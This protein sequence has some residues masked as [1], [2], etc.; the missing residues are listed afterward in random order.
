MN[1]PPVL[2]DNP[3][4][5]CNSS[6]L[7]PYQTLCKKLLKF[8]NKDPEFQ[9]NAINWIKSLKIQQ[10]IKYFSF[11]NQWFVDILHEMLLISD[12]RKDKDIKYSFIPALNYEN[13]QKQLKEIKFV[14]YFI[15]CKDDGKI[16]LSKNRTPEDKLKKK[17]VENLRYVTLSSNLL[18]NININTN[19]HILNNYYNDEN[20]E[21]INNEYN[22][23]VTLSY[24]YLSDIDNL[25][26]TFLEISRN[27]CFQCPIEV[28]SKI[29]KSGKKN[30]YNFKMPKWLEEQFT[31]QELLCAYFEQSILI[32]YQYYLLYQQEIP[33][34]YYDKFDEFL[35]NIYKLQEFIFNCKESVSILQSIKPEEIKKIYNEDKNIKKIIEYKKSIDDEIKNNY[36]GKY[37]YS[38]KHTIKTIITTNLTTLGHVFLKDKLN[39]ILNMTFIKDSILFTTDDFVLKIIYDLI[40]NNWQSKVAE[41]LLNNY[42]MNNDNNKKRKKKKKNKKEGKNDEKNNELE[43]NKDHNINKDFEKENAISN[44]INNHIQENEDYIRKDIDNVDNNNSKKIIGEEQIEE[45]EKDNIKINLIEGK[46]EFIFGDINNEQDGNIY[47]NEALIIDNKTIE[48]EIKNG[49]NNYKEKEEKSKEK[50]GDNKN[51]K[52]EENNSNDNNHKKKKDKNFFLYPTLKNKKKKNKQKKKEKIANN[53][54]IKDENFSQKESEIANNNASNKQ[55]EEDKKENKTEEEIKKENIIVQD[56]KDIKN[57][58]EKEIENKI[59]NNTI[60]EKDS[61][62]ENKEKIK[63]NKNGYEFVSTK[64]KNKFNMGMKLKNMLKDNSNLIIPKNYQPKDSSYNKLKFKNQIS[65]SF[66]SKKDETFES[67]NNNNYNSNIPVENGSYPSNINFMTGSNL[68]RF[69]SFNFNS[70]KKGK[71]YRNKHN[72]NIS[73]Y[74]F[75]SN[76]I[77]ELS[78]E[79]IDNTMKVNQNKGNLGKVREK[80]IKKIYELINIFLINEKLDFLCSFYGS[81]ISGLSIENSDIDIMVKLKENKNEKDYVNKIMNL[82]VDNLKKNNINYITNIIPIFSASVP[83]IKLECDLCNNDAFSEEV[84]KLMKAC[85]L[86]YN[87]IAKLYFDITFFVVENEQEKIPSELMIDYIKESIMNYPQIIDIVYIM[88][89]YLFNKKLNKSYQGGISSF[90]LFLLTLAFLKHFNKNKNYKIPIGS[91]LIEYLNYYANFNFY[92]TVIDPSKDD[93]IYSIIEDNSILYKYNLNIID[94]IT[95]LNVSKSTFKMDQIQKAFKDGL[96]KIVGN[97][98]I[99]NN[100]NID[101]KK[102]SKILGSFLSK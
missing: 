6:S 45:K 39:F 30:Y 33:F 72:I 2:F 43:K 34:L 61:T 41:D 10:L 60:N 62:E 67:D 73:P 71:N 97:L 68:P 46:E 40:N 101:N 35:E 65:L 74:N 7:I 19:N 56:Q 31:F 8:N 100:G 53:Y 64:Q 48:N 3:N 95:G 17:F 70:K 96:D 29:C 36:I 22:N 11:K 1:F 79:I 75:V 88:K 86:N 55:C 50:E 5:S 27:C 51:D 15:I 52:N 12:S 26:N 23:V 90:S 21:N 58:E 24:E 92:N 78:K 102:Q 66:Q 94:P 38:K 81:S 59:D 20:N 85:D 4:F 82:L 25:I 44:C 63:K 16:S 49:S 9:A 77:L 89:R 14:D 83:V 42:D 54:N 69:T 87:D 47:N 91:L 32:N 37:S 28:D 13:E 93:N 76:N 98:Y 99:V 84:N 18:E 57:E 80:F